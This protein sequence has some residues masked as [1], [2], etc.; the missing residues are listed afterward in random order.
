MPG[1]ETG[2]QIRDLRFARESEAQDHSIDHKSPSDQRRCFEIMQSWGFL[3]LGAS[4][5]AMGQAVLNG[6]KREKGVLKGKETNQ[7]L[8]CGLLEAADLRIVKC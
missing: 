3:V 7:A 8:D 5:S 4:E 6:S 2:M 1:A